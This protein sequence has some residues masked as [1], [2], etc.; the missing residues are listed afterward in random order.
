MPGLQ[1]VGLQLGDVHSHFA[2]WA[3]CALF[4]ALL[5]YGA[6]QWLQ[7][8]NLYRRTAAALGS[9]SFGSRIPLREA[10]RIAYE[11]ARASGSILA[12]AAERVGPDKSP[13]GILNYVA[14]YIAQVAL[15]WGKR[16]PSTKSEPIDPMQAMTGAFCD[17]PRHFARAALHTSCSPTCGSRE[18]TCAAWSRPFFVRA[19][20]PPR[21]GGT[22]R[23]L[24]VLGVRAGADPA[25]RLHQAKRPR[26]GAGR[27]GDRRAGGPASY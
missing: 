6:F 26:C 23:A 13:E 22:P 16:P 4:A 12:H 10:A 18:R 17:G 14:T 27:F 15:I 3:C 19:A 20:G 2:A 1:G 25:H 24:R 7:L 5:G 21:S 9:L 8:P 11:E